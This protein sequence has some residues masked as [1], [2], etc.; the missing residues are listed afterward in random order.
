MNKQKKLLE[1]TNE[2]FLFFI[3]NRDVSWFVESPPKTKK[4][5]SQTKRIGYFRLERN[6]LKLDVV[7][8]PC[9]TSIWDGQ[10]KGLASSGLV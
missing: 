3:E 5:K 10:N 8:H 7:A 1:G 9:N 2:H 6:T 4:W